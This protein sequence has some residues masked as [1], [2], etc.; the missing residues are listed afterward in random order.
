MNT[1]K[2]IR[3]S[4]HRSVGISIIRGTA[5]TTST[6]STLMAILSCVTS[7]ILS[8]STC[9]PRHLVVSCVATA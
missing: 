9:A 2:L 7:M 6:V 8:L 4:R 1:D 3:D 5:S